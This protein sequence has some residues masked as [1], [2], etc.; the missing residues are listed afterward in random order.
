MSAAPDVISLSRSSSP[1]L[2]SINPRRR[3]SGFVLTA[4]V[5][6]PAHTS[7]DWFKWI[8]GSRRDQIGRR[9]RLTVSCARPE[10]AA[11]EFPKSKMNFRGEMELSA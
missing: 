2:P 8:L 4:R 7:A 10:F 6:T 11:T 3:R 5:R 1:S 9:G